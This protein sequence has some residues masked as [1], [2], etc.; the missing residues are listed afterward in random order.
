MIIFNTT[1]HVDDSVHDDYLGFIREIYIP[2]A[3][4]SGFLRDGRLARILSQTGEPGTNYALQFRTKNGET[5]DLWMEQTGSRL[6]QEL[7]KRFGS[8]VAGFV[9]LMEEVH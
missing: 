2:R 1:F 6:G 7:V 8:K 9:T 4:E 3:S 5:L